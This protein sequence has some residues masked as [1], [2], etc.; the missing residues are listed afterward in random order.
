MRGSYVLTAKLNRGQEIK[1]GKLGLIKF[2]KGYYAYAGSALNGL[3]SRIRRHLRKRKKM[4]WHID[5]L[6][7]KTVIKEIF[8]R[9]GEEREECKFAKELG[10]Y[11]KSIK[12]FGSSDCK[13][14]SHLF[15]GKD[16]S[17][18]QLVIAKMGLNKYE[19]NG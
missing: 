13:C 5:Y 10:E 19:L 14:S 18:L 1:V 8:Y 3:E 16:Y 6:L 12:D 9:E 4:Y 2:D 17:Q 11:F 15:Y 7:E